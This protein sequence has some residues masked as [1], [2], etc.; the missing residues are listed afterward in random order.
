VLVLTAV[1][2]GCE[3]AGPYEPS[4]SKSFRFEHQ[5]SRVAFSERLRSE[6]VV[7]EELADGTIVFEN[8]HDSRIRAAIAAITQ[9]YYG[10]PGAVVDDAEY[11]DEL[12]AI[13]A[14]R[15]IEIRVVG[16][17]ERFGIHW[18]ES[19]NAV[20]NAILDEMTARRWDARSLPG[21]E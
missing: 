13:A 5:Q 3:N 8:P 20:V 7:F 18:D 9:E 19:D 17:D 15:G 16:L 2:T 14:A 1:L 6:R 11:K 4:P 10:Y 21:E 12:V